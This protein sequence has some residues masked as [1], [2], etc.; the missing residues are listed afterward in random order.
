MQG[1]TARAM[2]P[3][4]S[5][6]HIFVGAQF[7]GLSFEGIVPFLHFAFFLGRDF[8]VGKFAGLDVESG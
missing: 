5:P 6:H 8:L 3:A 1:E 4:P 7:L 2:L